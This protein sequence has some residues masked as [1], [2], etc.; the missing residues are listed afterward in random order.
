[1]RQTRV[2]QLDCQTDV[3]RIR[4]EK[5]RGRCCDETM[6]VGG[7]KTLER[8]TL[9]RGYVIQKDTKETGV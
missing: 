2:G 1:M 4:I 8:S 6:E 7:H 9:R 3:V 5:D